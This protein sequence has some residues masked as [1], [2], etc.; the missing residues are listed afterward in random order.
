[1]D[2]LEGICLS[3]CLHGA[4][5][6]GQTAKEIAVE[7]EAKCEEGED[8]QGFLKIVEAL[9]DPLESA[10]SAVR[11]VGTLAPWTVNW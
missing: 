7:Y 1:M 9:E 6:Q 10:W 4:A 2:Q 8:K 11:G 5:D 3:R